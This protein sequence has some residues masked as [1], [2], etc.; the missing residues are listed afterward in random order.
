MIGMIDSGVCL[1][2]Y[3]VSYME[4]IGAQSIIPMIP[5]EKIFCD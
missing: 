1:S 3:E 5:K 4:N 2:Y